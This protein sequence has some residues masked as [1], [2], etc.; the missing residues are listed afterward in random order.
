MVKLGSSSGRSI[1][2]LSKVRMVKPRETSTERVERTNIRARET[3]P[4]TALV[5]SM[6]AK[7]SN[8][9]GKE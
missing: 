3:Q 1:L 5:Y 8:V 2:V 9:R 4:L 7:A 6:E